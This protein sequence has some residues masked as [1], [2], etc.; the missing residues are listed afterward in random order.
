LS[1]SKN[2]YFGETKYL[3]LRADIFNVLNHPSYTLTNGNVFNATGIA[4]ATAS[5]GY[6]QPFSQSFLD[7]TQFAGGIRQ[8]TLGIKFFF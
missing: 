4:T 1:V 7:A 2:T 5:A 6:A 3:Q 8:M